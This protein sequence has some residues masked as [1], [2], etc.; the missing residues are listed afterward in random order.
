MQLDKLQ[1]KKSTSE[2][3]TRRVEGIQI[4]DNQKLSV[5]T[6]QRRQ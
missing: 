2:G 6:A 5:C 4:G 1:E 3:R